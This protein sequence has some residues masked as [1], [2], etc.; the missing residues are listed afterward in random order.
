MQLGISM[1]IHGGRYVEGVS[2]FPL[3]DFFECNFDE[4]INYL[5]NQKQNS[6]FPLWDF[7][8]CNIT[9]PAYMIKTKFGNKSSQFPLWDFFECNSYTADDP[10]TV[11]NFSSQFP[12][13]DFF[14]CN[15][16]SFLVSTRCRVIYLSI[17]FVG[18]L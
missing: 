17:P 6:Q 9:T 8:E 13:W 10:V 15:W 16:P 18:F 2:Q 11:F 4:V 12:L 3:W 5:L 7:F 14:E 1:Q